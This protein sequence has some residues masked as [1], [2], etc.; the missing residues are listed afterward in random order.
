M[1]EKQISI[2]DEENGIELVEEDGLYSL[3]DLWRQSGENQSKTPSKWLMQKGTKGFVE[4]IKRKNSSSHVISIVNGGGG[5]FGHWQIALAY[6]K[7]LSPELHEKVNQVFKDNLEEKADPN[8]AIDRGVE[9]AKES[10]KKHGKSNK[11]ISDRLISKGTRL[12]YTDTLKDHDCDGVG[13]GMNTNTQYK[14]IF[15]AKASELKEQKGLSKKDNLRDN[16]SILELSQIM[17]AEAMAADEIE[18]SD[19]RGN[20]KCN[21]VSKHAAKSVRGA[22]ENFNNPELN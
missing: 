7:Y 8:L 5:T 16:M 6:A 20:W 15:G 13:I 19:T 1:K 2:F 3:T 22:I 17:F 18:K 11:W 21:N 10:Y 9:R 14:E 12:H 4:H